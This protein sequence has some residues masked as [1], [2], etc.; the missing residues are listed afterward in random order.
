MTTYLPVTL[1]IHGRHAMWS[2]PRM[3]G[4]NNKYTSVIVAS[5]AHLSTSNDSQSQPAGIY[6][7]K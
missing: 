5:T 4:L 2:Y 1:G 7:R 6:N 3:S